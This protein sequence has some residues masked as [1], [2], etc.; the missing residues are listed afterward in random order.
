MNDKVLKVIRTMFFKSYAHKYREWFKVF[1]LVF[2]VYHLWYIIG[3]VISASKISQ[4]KDHS[5]KLNE[6]TKSRLSAEVSNDTI[7]AVSKNSIPIEIPNRILYSSTQSGRL[8]TSARYRIY[9]NIVVGNQ[10][11][12][13]STEYEVTL[14][15]F[16][17]IDKLYW[18]LDVARCNILY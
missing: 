16:A 6:I 2:M 1:L 4:V 14:A 7:H 17:S 3:S 18:I 9:E 5:S 12:Q 11:K 13:I 10:F 15:S 8:D